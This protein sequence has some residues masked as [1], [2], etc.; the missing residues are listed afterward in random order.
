M[1]R[2]KTEKYR[3][4]IEHIEKNERKILNRKK[5]HRM[6]TGERKNRWV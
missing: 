2:E 5:L 1:G 4:K 3:E 6:D